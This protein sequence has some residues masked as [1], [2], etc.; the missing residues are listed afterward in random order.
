M[1]NQFVNSDGNEKSVL[2]MTVL[3]LAVYQPVLLKQINVAT[4][5]C[6]TENKE[7]KELFQKTWNEAMQKVEFEF[8]PIRI[9]LVEKSLQLER[10][11]KN[12]LE[13]HCVKSVRIWSF[14]GPCFSA[15]GLN[16]ER[17]GA[18]SPNA[19]KYGPEKL[20][21]LTLFSQ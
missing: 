17:Y 3:I 11:K 18:F 2:K 9:I 19:G 6:E 13:R 4:V 5:D 16:T 1:R 14:S 8:N 21:I 12:I 10:N 20:Q 15:F 7:S